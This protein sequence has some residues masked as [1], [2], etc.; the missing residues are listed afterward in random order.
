MTRKYGSD[1]TNE[2]WELIEPLI[3]APKCGG[4]PRTTDIREVINALF[5]L[6]RTGCQWR[7]LPINFPPHQTVYRYFTQ[8]KKDGTFRRVYRVIYRMYRFENDREV[9]PSVLC[10]DSQSVKTGKAGG[11]RGY[12]GGKRV[13]GRKRHLVTDTLGL[14]V[15]VAVTAANVH[16]KE[17]GKKV[18]SRVAKW[19]TK[20]I[21]RLYA[22]GGYSGKPFADWVREKIGA[23]VEIAVNLAQTFKRFIPAK[24]RWVVER[25]FAW[26][27]DYRRLDKDHERLK[28]S[29][30]GMVRIASI[31]M[32]LKKLRP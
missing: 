1:L 8:W 7:Q 14:P 4:R 24:K 29:S 31:A 12:D 16:D 25:T 11:D 19:I 3:P 22:D 17:G 21:K 30:L 20:P 26:L 18:L 13:K 9:S 32:I 28:S 10:I 27:A 6:A 2:H 5:Y 23:T 15:D